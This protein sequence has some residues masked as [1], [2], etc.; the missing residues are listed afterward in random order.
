V[1]VACT[2]ATITI[3]DSTATVDSQTSLTIGGDG[4]GLIAYPDAVPGQIGKIK[5]A[6]CLTTAC[7]SA[8]LTTVDTRAQD[9]SL[10]IATG[11]NG[12]GLLAYRDSTGHLDVRSCAS[13]DCSAGT[14]TTVDST[15]DNSG[16]F[17]S[18]TQGQDGLGLVTYGR[19][20]TFGGNLELV[21]AHC[22]DAQ[23][24][25]LTPTVVDTLGAVSGETSITTG[26]DGLGIV[27]YHDAANQ[28]LKVAHCANV[29]CS[30]ATTR[31]VDEFGDMGHNPSISIGQDGLPFISYRDDTNL[32]LKTAH[33][34]DVAC[35][36]DLGT[37]FRK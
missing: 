9:L 12:L 30:S 5:V 4:L 37:I 17:A 34:P 25:R 23:C 19:F 7:T 10:S 33:C 20:A 21:V 3:L 32:V 8:S 28:N 24:T 29:A 27:S 16:L 18:I 11:A 36:G 14:T 13:P 6:H 2:S 1:D 35:L 22:V 31:A 15:G 26:V